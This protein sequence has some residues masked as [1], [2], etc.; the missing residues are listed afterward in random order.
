MEGNVHVL[1]KNIY[2]TDNSVVRER[3][4]VYNEYQK[5]IIKFSIGVGVG[6]CKKIILT[7]DIDLIQGGIQS[8]DDEFL[9]WFV[10][11]PS[12][13]RVEVE[14]HWEIDNWYRIIIPQEEPKQELHACK[15]CGA[16]TTQSDDE[17]YAK[18]KQETLE[19]AAKEIYKGEYVCNGIDIVPAWRQGFVQGAK[20]DAAKDYWYKK[21]WED[22]ES[23]FKKQNNEI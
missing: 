18:P 10:K 22:Y 19:E 17:C 16:E 15:H 20:S 3:D 2:I 7:N 6:L 4:W 23:Q 11:N 21:F 5:T 14:K 1:E 8:I 9:Q 12:C 13:K